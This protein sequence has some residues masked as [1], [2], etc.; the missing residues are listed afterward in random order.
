MVV[1]INYRYWSFFKGL[2]F[3]FQCALVLQLFAVERFILYHLYFV[4]STVFLIFFKFLQNFF[5][6]ILCKILMPFYGNNG[7]MKT[8][9]YSNKHNK[10]TL[11]NKK[12]E[13]R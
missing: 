5:L 2:L 12:G 8:T 13:I 9:I 3:T 7:I 1:Q 10:F 11:A 4:L 6:L